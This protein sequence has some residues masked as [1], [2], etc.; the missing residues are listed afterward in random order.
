MTIDRNHIIYKIIRSNK[1]NVYSIQVRQNF[2]SVN[3]LRCKFEE[4]TKA[5]HLPSRSDLASETEQ[6]AEKA[7]KK[8]TKNRNKGIHINSK[9]QQ[10]LKPAMKF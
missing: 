2:F 7:T 3:K 9:E 8:S 4:T 5:S 10:H 1:I 6:N